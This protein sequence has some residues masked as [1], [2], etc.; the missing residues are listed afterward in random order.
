MRHARLSR[1]ALGTC[2]LSLPAWGGYT[3]YFR[4]LQKPE[5]APLRASIAE[6][7]AL[8]EARK[9]ILAGPEG[10]KSPEFTSDSLVVNGIGDDS[11]EPFIFP[12]YTGV[13]EWAP[14]LTPGFNFCKTAGKPYDEVVTACLLVARDHFPVSVLA[15]GSDGSWCGGDWR[16]GSDLYSKVLR[17]P[18]ANPIAGEVV[19]G[20]PAHGEGVCGP[21]TSSLPSAGVVA[22]AIGLG[23]A[24]FLL[25]KTLT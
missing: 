12:G 14:K 6:M 20:D 11:H 8:A 4:W 9:A 18:A 22:V 10:E 3:H 25:K 23:V 24:F 5:D 16:A 2:I 15:I 13:I 17:R 21:S 19:P 1:L 7:R